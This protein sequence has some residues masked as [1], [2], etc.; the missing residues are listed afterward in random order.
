MVMHATC[1]S[2]GVKE[3]RYPKGQQGYVL[4][5]TLALL[6]VLG[7]VAGRLHATVERFQ[8]QTGAWQGW[9]DGQARLLAA[10]D[11]TLMYML[12]HS[13]SDWGFGLGPQALRVDGR[14]YRLPS[15]VL[16]SVQD[17]RGLLG[18]NAYQPDLM[19][20]FLAQRG[21]EAAAVDRLLDTLDD[22]TDLDEFRR[23]NGAEKEAYVAAGLPE[24]RNDWLVSPYELGRVL[25]WRD[26]RWLNPRPSDF[27]AAHREPWLNVN[28]ASRDVLMSL[29]TSPESAQRLVERRERQPFVNSAELATVTGIVLPED[30]IFWFFPGLFYRLRVWLADGF[31]V[32]ESH[33]M[34][35]P[36]GKSS[37]W[38]ILEVRQISRQKLL[39]DQDEISPFPAPEVVPA[40]PGAD[41]S[42]G[43]G[44]S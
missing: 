27:F 29:T 6:A 36:G 18:L 37:P 41:R 32:L 11:E 8:E 14:P 4:V 21:V 40:L 25:R 12:T 3:R 1:P 9:G 23:L 15:G 28:T 38:R 22:F 7:I 10:R 2:E 24:P 39:N 31:P 44:V 35:T 33:I 19:R 34:L 5:A 20:R 43:A 16:V 26:L 17:E 13:I 42:D 30:E